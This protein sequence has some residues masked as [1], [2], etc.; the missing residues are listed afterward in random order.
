MMTQKREAEVWQRVMAASAECPPVQAAPVKPAVGLTAQQVM[1]LL[2][3]ELLDVCTYR[4]LAGRV[5]KEQRRLLLQLAQ[6]EQRHYRKLEA[7][8]YLMTGQR[9]CPERPKAPCM[10]CT[11]E[12]L[13]KR[14]QQEAAGAETY[15]KLAEQAGSFASVFHCLGHEEERHAAVILE[16]LQRC[17]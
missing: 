17:L 15:H 10:A 9:P 14:Y 16:L 1:E 6:A 8:Y 11:S 7:I 5:R 12:E 13:R 2:E 3:K 4:T